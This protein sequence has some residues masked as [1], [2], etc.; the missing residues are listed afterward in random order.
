M[1]KTFSEE[2]AHAETR[3]Y[4]GYMTSIFLF[5]LVVGAMTGWAIW[6]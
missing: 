1:N 2:L 4:I 3:Y 5:G 6:G